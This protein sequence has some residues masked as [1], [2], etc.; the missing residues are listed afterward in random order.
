MVVDI[1]YGFPTIHFLSTTKT[2]NLLSQKFSQNTTKNKNKIETIYFYLHLLF[3]RM[4]KYI[5]RI[6]Y[7]NLEYRKDRKEDIESELQKYDLLDKSERFIGFHVPD[8]GILGCSK[9]HLEVLKIAKERGYKNILILEDDFEFV[10]SKEEFE[11]NLS[12]FF[13][14]GLE[15]DVC[16]ISFN[17]LENSDDI[18]L[19]CPVVRRVLN[20]Q[21]ASGYIVNS[22]YL[23][24][25]ISLYEWSCPLL[26]ETKEHWNYANDQCWKS[27]QPTD[28][29]YHFIER[30][31]KQRSGFSDN[32]MRF[33]EYTC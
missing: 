11:R 13:E 27:L 14:S 17:N 1:C 26:E 8:Q 23:D 29:W 30:M 2:N 24:R 31:G 33:M 16:M 9:S 4:S 25:L 28:K 12:D 20:S 6:V 32:S 19:E 7:I 22:A 5:D 18:V 3:E 15:Y 10:V 21:T